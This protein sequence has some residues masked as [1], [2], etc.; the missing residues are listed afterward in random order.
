MNPTPP[1]FRI[2]EVATLVS[3]LFLICLPNASANNIETIEFGGPNDPSLMGTTGSLSIEGPIDL[4]SG[5]F[6]AVWKMTFDGFDGSA[7]KHGELTHV[8]FNAFK[9]IS[10]VTLE[11]VIWTSPVSGVPLSPSNI[12]NNGCATSTGLVSGFVC[13]A[14]DSP[15]DVTMGGDFS[16]VFQVTGTLKDNEWSYRGKFGPGDGGVISEKASMSAPT[17]PV[18][19]PTA[20]LVFAA[21]I[22]VVGIAIRRSPHR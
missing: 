22:L 7:T 1:P 9:D 20:P 21:G 10:V 5:T 17:G 15:V 11:E 14:L 13:M 3:I 12:S 2:V 6:D 16:A 18:P 8:A 4:G 19:E